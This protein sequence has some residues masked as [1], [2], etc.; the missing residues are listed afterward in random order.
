MFWLI[1]DCVDHISFNMTQRLRQG[2]D[3]RKGRLGEASAAFLSYRRNA[4]NSVSSARG[5]VCLMRL[6]G[7]PAFRLTALRTH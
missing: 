3:T 7:F 6:S 4:L 2:G 5:P 1:D